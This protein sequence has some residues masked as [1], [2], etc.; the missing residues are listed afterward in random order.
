MSTLSPATLAQKDPKRPARHDIVVVGASAGGV[1]ALADFAAWLPAI[2]PAAVFIVLHI[3]AYEQ[4]VL[5]EI[6]G[7][8]GLMSVKHAEDG[9]PIVEGR[10]Y[11]APPDYH[12]LMEDGKVLL[13]HG[14]AENNHRPA[15]DTLFRSAARSYGPRVVGLVLTGRPDDGTAGLQS[16]QDARRHGAG[17]GPERSDV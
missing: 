8:R 5:P 7:R 4:S 3:P 14:P 1:E 10:I 17:A 15:I 9:E 2:L 16:M 13:T 6:L 12:L 11:V